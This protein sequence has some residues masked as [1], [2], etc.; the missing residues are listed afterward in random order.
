MRPGNVPRRPCEPAVVRPVR[1][2][3]GARCP[4]REPSGPEGA[5]GRAG[6]G[7]PSLSPK[8][9]R[10]RRLPPTVSPMH[11]ISVAVDG[12]PASERALD[13]AIEVAAGLK[14]S[15]SVISVVPFHPVMYPGPY[16]GPVP[17]SVTEGEAKGYR[18]LLERCRSKAVSAGLSEVR[19]ELRQ[20]LIVDELLDLLRKDPPDLLVCGS[21]GLSATKRILLGSISEALVHH[22]PCPVLVDRPPK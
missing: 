10:S 15:L 12:S 6:L 19:T 2:L 5:E 1:V 9:K 16:P 11:R 7:A 14:A 21:R 22:A 17:P 13:L 18:D 4:R 8:P 3:G 20:G